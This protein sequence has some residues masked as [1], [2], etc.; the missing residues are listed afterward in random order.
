MRGM[1]YGCSNLTAA[2]EIHVS[3]SNYQDTFSYMFTN[4]T[5]MLS[6]KLDLQSGNA[7]RLMTSMYQGCSSL[8]AIE[9]PQLTA[10]PSQT[11]NWV[12]G[13]AAAGTFTCPTAL[14]TN[15][16]IT[17]GTSNC[18]AGWTVVNTDAA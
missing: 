15:E 8:T 11:T 17:R 14:G 7:T 6:A 5:G 1:F 4:C 3:A 10:W 13:V 16:T 18:P 12:N 2:P 9:C